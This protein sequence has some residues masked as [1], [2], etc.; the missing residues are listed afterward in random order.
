MDGPI[1]GGLWQNGIFQ[2]PSLHRNLCVRESGDQ[3]VEKMREV[4]KNM[5]KRREKQ[6]YMCV[7][8]CV[9]MFAC[10]CSLSCRIFSEYPLYLAVI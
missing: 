8:E 6:S 5:L 9:C 10:G 4:E 2:S 3:S 1:S 7:Y